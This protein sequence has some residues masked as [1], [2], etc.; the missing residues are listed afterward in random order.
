MFRVQDHE[1]CKPDGE[2]E[3]QKTAGGITQGVSANLLERFDG[4]AEP[5]LEVVPSLG[6]FSRAVATSPGPLLK[7]C[8]VCASQSAFEAQAGVVL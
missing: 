6:L 5:V 4:F 2:E 1:T 3:H 8:Q 7:S